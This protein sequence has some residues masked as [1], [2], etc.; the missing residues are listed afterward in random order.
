LNYQLYVQC[1]SKAYNEH[2]TQQQ[3]VHTERPGRRTT[4]L[5]TIT[6]IHKHTTGVW[7]GTM[8]MVGW[9]SKV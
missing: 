1:T 3:Y 9:L 2:K 4:L 5:A 8:S 6:P 7:G